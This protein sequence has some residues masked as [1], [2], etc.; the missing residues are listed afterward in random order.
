MQAPSIQRNL[1]LNLD[2]NGTITGKDSIKQTN[3]Y[4]LLCALAKNT[5]ANWGNDSAEEEK[6]APTSFKQYVDHVLVPG[7]KSD[8]ILKKQRS[9]I[10]A[11]FLE[12]L[13]QNSP[14]LYPR[15][16][17]D[18][19]RMKRIFT[20]PSNGETNF[21]V[22]PSFY[23]LLNKLREMEISFT[24]VLRSFGN[25]LPD[26][27]KEIEEHDSGLRITQWAEFKEKK[28]M[29]QGKET[30]EKVDEIF[31]CFLSPNT[32][33]AVKDDWNAWNRDGERGRSGK[34]F[35]YSLEGRGRVKNLSLFFDDNIT[36]EEE[37]D[38]VDP[39]EIT[40][41]VVPKHSLCDKLIFQVNTM[42]AVLD[43]D[44]YINLVMKAIAQSEEIDS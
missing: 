30:L 7:E 21:T 38:I 33:F 1:I 44:Y 26:V 11:D 42:E 25:D 3:D 43:N 34:P 18:Y 29:L 40:G 36:G 4:M 39:Y 41:K 15:V 16:L 5:F 12:W 13:S 19:H 37:F 10:I 20:N 35:L 14:N 31:D 22:F 8:P 17:E 24:L 9:A 32:H 2:V 23:C 27:V 28:F 6:S